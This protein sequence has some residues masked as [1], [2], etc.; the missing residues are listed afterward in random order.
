MNKIITHEGLTSESDFQSETFNSDRTIYEVI[1]V[2]EGIGIF[3]EDHFLRLKQSFG[4]QSINFEMSF[5]NFERSVS[6][7]ININLK[8]EGNI[9]FAYSMTEKIAQWAFY[10]IPHSYPTDLDF[11]QGVSTD[12][13]HNERDNPNA[14]VIQ[15]RIREEANHLISE[16]NIYEILLVDRGGMITEGSRSNVFFVKDGVF[17]TAPESMVLVGI[18]RQKVIECIRQ[19]GFCL[20]E[21][22]VSESDIYRFDAVFITGTSPKVLPVRSI[23]NQK[24]NTKLGSVSDLMNSYNK[25]IEQYIW[26][27]KTSGTGYRIKI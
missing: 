15:T 26:H 1:R 23:R 16:R 27:E 10:F 4:N 22:A 13:L 18:T 17:Y 24:Y 12:L 21:E 14:K 25:I 6:E 5:D 20:V 7:L 11:I 3:L 19:L 9:K 8:I 2:I